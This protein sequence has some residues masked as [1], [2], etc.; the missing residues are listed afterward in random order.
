M[1]SASGNLSE[2]DFLALLDAYLMWN[3]KEA[4]LV[5][6]MNR[7]LSR[8]YEEKASAL[9]KTILRL[10][11]KRNLKPLRNSLKKISL[12]PSA[13]YCALAL[14]LL[15]NSTDI[16]KTIKKVEQVGYDVRYWCQI[17]MG[18]IVEKRMKE[19]GGPVPIELL[20]IYRRKGFW[21]GDLSWRSK[22]AA[23]DKLLLKYMGNRA[24]YLRLVAHAMIGAARRENLDLLER[25]AQHDYRMI[26]RAAAARLA[27]LAGD[28]GIKVL[29]SAVTAAI[30]RGNA[31][32]FG[33]AVRDA[34]IQRFGLVEIW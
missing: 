27:Q 26:A 7:R 5:G 25:L 9:A 15:G 30:E 20:R 11:T 23:K 32:A 10:S 17:E 21:D 8:V 14:V 2:A 16:V 4:G 3:Q 13:Q 19:I 12:T 22:V 31:E 6:K 24:L 33:L 34:E 1:N 18:R 29:Q 28:D